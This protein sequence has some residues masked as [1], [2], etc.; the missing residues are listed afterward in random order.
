MADEEL[1]VELKLVLSEARK[2][3]QEANEKLTSADRLVAR[4]TDQE[5]KDAGIE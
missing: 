5:K 1:V 2:A 4:L 3:M